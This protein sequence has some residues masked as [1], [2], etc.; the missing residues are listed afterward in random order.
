[1]V[2]ATMND[3]RPHAE[4][5]GGDT[6]NNLNDEEERTEEEPR[7]D[8]GELRVRHTNGVTVAGN[9]D[10]ECRRYREVPRRQ[11]LPAARHPCIAATGAELS[12][13]AARTA[14]AA[15]PWK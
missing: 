1:M 9:A 3:A 14:A 13:Y 7:G 4:A 2:A 5:G 8:V 15:R 10:S 11:V 12:P 6:E